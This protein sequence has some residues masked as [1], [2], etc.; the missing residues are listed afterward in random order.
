ML[1]FHC[2]SDRGCSYWDQ[3]KSYEDLL[4]LGMT[5]IDTPDPEPEIKPGEYRIKRID[6]PPAGGVNVMLQNENGPCPLISISNILAI[7]NCITIEAEKNGRITVDEI[8]KRIADYIRKQNS[9]PTIEQAKMINDVINSLNVLQVGL[10]VNFGF[11]SCDS[12]EVTQQVKV[13][14][15]LKIRMLHGWL[16]DP[17]SKEA[18]TIG[19]TTYNDLTLKLVTLA[20]AMSTDN[21]SSGNDPKKLASDDKSTEQ[22]FTPEEGA[23]VNEFLNSTSHQL[24]EF[25]LQQLHEVIKEDELVVFFRNNH[26]STLTKHKGELYNLV[27]DIGYERERNVVWDH[28]ASVYGDSSFYSSEFTNT[29]KVKLEEAINTA[30][31]SGFDKAKAEEAIQHVK[32][33]NEELK[34]EAVLDWL[35][36]HG[37]QNWP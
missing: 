4:E 37:Q 11:T 15:V 27:T 23:I 28:L 13:F 26:F 14:E 20:E 2:D 9:S 3:G 10:D 29:D 35:V 1:W 7:R 12:F 22:K 36:K 24:T 18:A 30:V 33:P 32:K 17:K 8:V 25:G 16:V 6:L 21:N 31:L 34:V 5:L 19:T